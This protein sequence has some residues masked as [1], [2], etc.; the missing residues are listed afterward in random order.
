MQRTLAK[1]KKGI[2]VQPSQLNEKWFQN[3]ET[4]PIKTNL[5]YVG[6]LR[7]EK[8]IFSLIKM[9][10]NKN[11]SLTIVTSEKEV[12]LK[13]N[14]KNISLITFENK[15]DAIIKIYDECNILILT[16]LY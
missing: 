10:K 9:V 1:K 11:L 6:R 2:V 3:R 4:K 14:Y 16:I 7:I 8:G 12:K 5:L 13:D 15:N